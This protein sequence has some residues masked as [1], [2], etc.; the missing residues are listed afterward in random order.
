MG[1]GHMLMVREDAIRTEPAGKTSDDLALAV[2]RAVLSLC[3]ERERIPDD[4]GGWRRRWFAPV[5]NYSSGIEWAGERHT[6]EEDLFLWAGNCLRPISDVDR[7]VL[8]RI[9]E[10]VT[11]MLASRGETTD[12]TA[13]I[14]E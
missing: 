5:L 4:Q 10:K 3:L 12:R 6:N 7:A 9:H 14:E 1:Y 11:R 13:A 8:E 2:G